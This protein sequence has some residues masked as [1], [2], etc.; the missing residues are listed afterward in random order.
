MSVNFADIDKN[1]QDECD[2][3][4]EYRL[5]RDEDFKRELQQNQFKHDEKMLEKKIDVLNKFTDALNSYASIFSNPDRRVIIINIPENMNPV[6]M[7][8]YVKELLIE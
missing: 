2:A 6:Y 3:Y 8:Q 1:Y 7:A 4:E 5:K